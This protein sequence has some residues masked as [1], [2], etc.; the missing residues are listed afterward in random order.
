MVTCLK[1]II[2]RVYISHVSLSPWSQFY[3]VKQTVGKSGKVRVIGFLLYSLRHFIKPAPGGY[4]LYIDTCCCQVSVTWD[5][6]VKYDDGVD[7]KEEL[8][9]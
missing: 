4:T 9:L 2:I 8:E 3:E 5:D 6:D 7:M 1:N